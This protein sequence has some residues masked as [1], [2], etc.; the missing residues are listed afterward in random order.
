LEV[1]DQWKRLQNW[2]LAD[3]NSFTHTLDLV[4]SFQ[5]LLRVTIEAQRLMRTILAFHQSP[6]LQTDI[7]ADEAVAGTLLLLQRRLD[8][9]RI[10]VFTDVPHI[11]VAIGP[12]T[13]QQILLNLLQ[14][15]MDVIEANVAED[16]W[17][18]IC[19]NMDYETRMLHI[20]VSNAGAKID[21]LLARQIFERGFSTKGRRGRGLGLPVSRR[22][23]KRFHGDLGLDE[24]AE[25]TTFVLVLPLSN[26][27]SVALRKESRAS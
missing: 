3:L 16:R 11:K 21:P 8:R 15:A 9:M 18:E 7:Y 22:L 4:F 23:V 1:Q 20:G 13:L 17:I 2:A 26:S 10:K 25:S 14:N 6:L 19:G 12:A 5:E 27:A 24:Q